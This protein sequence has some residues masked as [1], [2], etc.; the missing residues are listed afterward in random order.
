MDDAKRRSAELAA[1]RGGVRT[2]VRPSCNLAAAG[3][4]LWAFAG[5]SG[6]DFGR[7]ASPAIAIPGPW[8]IP[9]DVLAAGDAQYVDFTGA[10]PWRG[11]EGCGGGLLE[12]TGRLREYVYQYFPQ[13]WEIGGYSCR[14]IVGDPNSMSVHATG[15]ALDI[16]IYPV[17]YPDGSEADNEMGDPIGNWLIVN[18][19]RIGIQQ[20]I[21]DRWLWRAED[22]AGEKDRAYTGEHPHNDHL[23]VELSVEA[24][25]L[26]TP[27]FQ[28]EQG[29]PEL[30]SC[31]KIPAEGGTIDDVDRCA[32]FFGPPQFWRAVDGSG[33][34]GGLL[35]TDSFEADEPS[36]WAK[37]SL[38]L[39]A[40]GRYRVEY[41][42]VAGYAVAPRVR[43][44][45]G[46]AGASDVIWVDQ[47]AAEGWVSLGEF[48]F[49][50][51]GYQYVAIFDNADGPVADD[52]HIVFDA[53][54]L[55][56][57]ADEDCASGGGDDGGDDGS[58]DGG[59][60]D[61]GGDDGDGDPPGPDPGTGGEDGLG[62]GG[63]C[64][65]AGSS[66]SS[67]VLGFLLMLLA[68]GWVRRRR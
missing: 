53:L 32:D 25:A 29:P 1:P 59:G 15:R 27:F 57:C 21:W 62:G 3:A 37:W 49:A 7:A 30:P 34:G 52:Q 33:E 36:N 44:E 20:I 6:E 4:L 58:G 65:T 63:G 55:T 51:G 28:E 66:G 40:A 31:G 16:M 47:G 68:V 17:G 9:D 64:A 50:A 13:A 41:N 12:G 56:P 46:H 2:T 18:A 24:A 11:E 14:P 35:W 5:C 42:A 39:A 67:G 22:A 19:E 45:V 10:G 60:D 61:G 43:Y 48:D 54:R 8:V 38:D 23:H 26:G